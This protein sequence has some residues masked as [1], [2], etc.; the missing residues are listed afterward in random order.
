MKNTPY[1]FLSYSRRDR[2][3]ATALEKA[4]EASG[5]HARGVVVLVTAAT[6]SSEWVTYEYTLA[7]GSGVPVIAVVVHGAKVPDPVRQQFQ[8][9]DYL[10]ARSAAKAITEGIRYQSRSIVRRRESAPQL[11]A[12][13]Q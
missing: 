10:E 1:V 3:Q 6:A 9:V 8:T 4:L 7:A 2:V 5:L 13:F 12:K 11:L